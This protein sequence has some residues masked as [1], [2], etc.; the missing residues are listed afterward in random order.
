MLLLAVTIGPGDAISIGLA[1]LLSGALVAAVR[2][3]GSVTG[4]TK[5]LDRFEKRVAYLEE[6]AK[7][8]TEARHALELRLVALERAPGSSGVYEG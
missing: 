7:S 5:D 4:L 1:L 2:L 8:A 6:H 3:A